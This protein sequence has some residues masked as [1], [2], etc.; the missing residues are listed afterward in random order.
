M[1]EPLSPGT[2]PCVSEIPA[3]PCCDQCGK[4][5]PGALPHGGV[6]RCLG[7]SCEVDL[8]RITKK[9]GRQ[10]IQRELRF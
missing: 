4:P 9:V 3:D 7:C 6:Y 10:G 2:T 5:L 1:I 8:L